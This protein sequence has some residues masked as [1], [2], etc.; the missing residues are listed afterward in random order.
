MTGDDHDRF[1]TIPY[2]TKMLGM[3]RGWYYRHM[4]EPGVPQRVNVGGKV[5][6]SLNDCTAYVEHLKRQS[7]HHPAPETKRGPG[8]P[9]KSLMLPA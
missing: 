5:M 2:F 6:L 1:V 9:R 3:H 4:R 8:R 7:G